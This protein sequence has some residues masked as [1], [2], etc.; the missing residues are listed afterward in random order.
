MTRP[1][2]FAWSAATPALP[3]G[4]LPPH[5][6]SWHYPLTTMKSCCE[7]A[8]A[9]PPKGPARRFLNYALY[10]ALAAV[11]GFVLWQQFQA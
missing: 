5:P 2:F 8:G 7:Q 6:I 3:S 9:P 10:A 1:G 4:A 11:L